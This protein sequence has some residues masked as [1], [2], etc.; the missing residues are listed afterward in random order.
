[1]PIMGIDL[2]L[3]KSQ[4]LPLLKVLL[5]ALLKVLLKVLLW[6]CRADRQ[7][8]KDKIAFM[9][10]GSVD[11]VPLSERSKESKVLSWE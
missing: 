11:R 7:L 9:V 3:D 10:L 4:C 1:M 2:D 5:Q 8:N 6:L